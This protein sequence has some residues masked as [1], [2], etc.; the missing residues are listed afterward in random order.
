MKQSKIMDEPDREIV[1]LSDREIESSDREW[2]EHPEWK[3]IR[4]K[5][6]LTGKDTGNKF[7]YHLVHIEK[8]CEIPKHLHEKEWELN[9]MI[10]GKGL[11]IFDNKEI[12]LSAGQ[13][14]ATPPGVS[15]AVSSYDSEMSL[16]ALFIPVS[17]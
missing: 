1:F 9:R 16:L 14:F 17:D 10:K 12:T 3:G 4:L 15:H 11:F 7:S 13:T 8:N 5:D 2:Y 6:L